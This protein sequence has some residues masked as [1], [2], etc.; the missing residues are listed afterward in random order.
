MCFV[1]WSWMGILGQHFDRCRFW[2]LHI[3]YNSPNLCRAKLVK[4]QVAPKRSTIDCEQL[5][6]PNDGP[7]SII[8]GL[9]EN[10]GSKSGLDLTRVRRGAVPPVNLPDMNSLL[11]VGCKMHLDT[12]HLYRR[13]ECTQ[14]NSNRFARSVYLLGNLSRGPSS[15]P[16]RQHPNV[17]HFHE[18]DHNMFANRTSAVRGN[19]EQ[20]PYWHATSRHFILSVSIWSLKTFCRS[21][22]L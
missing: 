5:T 21:T 14:V 11:P 8:H 20:F 13:Y 22:K 3:E 1:G 12:G 10:L 15:S 6:W 17:R 19:L 18:R 4:Y 2:R 7:S 9:H 16:L